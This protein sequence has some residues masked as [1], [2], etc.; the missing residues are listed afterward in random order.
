[1]VQVADPAIGTARTVSLTPSDAVAPSRP[2]SEPTRAITPRRSTEPS[3]PG[4]PSMPVANSEQVAIPRRRG[5]VIALAATVIVGGVLAFALTRGGDIVEQAP[6][7]TPDAAVARVEPD[8]SP[9][10]PPDAPEPVVPAKVMVR[11]TSKPAGAEIRVAG[12]L[13]GKSPLDVPLDRGTSEVAI[14][15]RIGARSVTKTV[16]P[17]DDRSIELVV[18]VPAAVKPNGEKTPF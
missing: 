12:Q 15:A 7:V 13:K 16:I 9:V 6:V 11:V 14:E 2:T 10:Q 4:Q 8:A 18:P 1:M 5:L 17:D 3:A